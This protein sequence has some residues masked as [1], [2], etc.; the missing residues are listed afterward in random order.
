[1]PKE[2]S[3]PMPLKYVV[4]T[5]TTH[6]SLDVLQEGR[7]DDHWNVDVDRNLSDSWTGS[8]KFTQVTETLPKGY[9]WSRWPRTKIQATARPDDLWPE[10]C[11]ECQKQ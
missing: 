5:R 9:V 6:T 7:I 4:V 11:Q 3:F 10:I 8:T 1:M 2:E